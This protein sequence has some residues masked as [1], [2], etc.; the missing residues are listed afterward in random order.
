MQSYLLFPVG[1]KER[2]I[3]ILVF[4]HICK[5]I[6]C[7]KIDSSSPISDK[8]K[9]QLCR[10]NVLFKMSVISLLKHQALTFIE[11]NRYKKKRDKQLLENVGAQYMRQSTWK[12]GNDLGLE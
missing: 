5:L 2:D 1:D 6:F 8:H 3:S 4:H 9:L 12:G 11:L 7:F 10:F